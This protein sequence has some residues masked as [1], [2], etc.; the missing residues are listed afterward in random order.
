MP[1]NLGFCFLLRDTDQEVQGSHDMLSSTSEK[2]LFH[3][4]LG[5]WLQAEKGWVREEPFLE[6]A[7]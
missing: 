1:L 5:K 4:C 7:D 2:V 3:P 6:Q